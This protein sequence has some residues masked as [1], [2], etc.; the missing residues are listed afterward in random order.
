M[1]NRL[2]LVLDA[3]EDLPDFAAAAR[4]LE[5]LLPGIDTD[6][7]AEAFPAV[8]DV[9]DFERALEVGAG[10]GAR[11]RRGRTGGGG[12]SGRR[13]RWFPRR[14]ERCARREW[15][16]HSAGQ[17]ALSL[18]RAGPCCSACAR[19]AFVSVGPGV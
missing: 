9:G 15:R 18:L 14:A 11:A 12:G 8:L 5:A 1:A 2:D 10:R 3:E 17:G 19:H 13:A 6:R 7:F 4:R 16:G